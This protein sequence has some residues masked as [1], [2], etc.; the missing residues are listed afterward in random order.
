MQPGDVVLIVDVKD[1][2]TFKRKGADLVIKRE[3]TL[4]ESLTGCDFELNHL[5]GH[6]VRVRSAPG[7]V[8]KPD[9]VLQVP[10]EGMPVGGHSHVKGVLFV[11]FDI[12]FPDK[13]ELSDAMV[14]VLGGML[15]KPE[16]PRPTGKSGAVERFLEEPDMEA[17]KARERLGK[18]AYDS[19]EEDGRGGAPGGVRCA[20]Q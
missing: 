9:V 13:L 3:I 10:E 20:Q 15:P 18:D 12:K 11:Q 8:I 7:Q 4:L 2:A 14:K 5:D 1:H 6:K 17:R 19:D 16:G